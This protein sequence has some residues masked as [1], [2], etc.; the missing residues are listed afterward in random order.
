MDRL[1]LVYTKTLQCQKVS[2]ITSL[3]TLSFILGL[4]PS[5]MKK[6]KKEN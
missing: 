3:D 2:K 5:L 1:T 6:K 4:M